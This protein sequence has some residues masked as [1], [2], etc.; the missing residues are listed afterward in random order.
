[1]RTLKDIG[2]SRGKKVLVRLDL[3]VPI[4][5]G[6]VQNDFRIRQSLPTINFLKEKGARLILVSHLGKNGEESLEP[7]FTVLRKHL[8]EISFYSSLP[9]DETLKEKIG[10][11][12]DGEILLLENLRKNPGEEKNGLVFSKELASLADLYVND[13]FSAS[14]REHASIVGVPKIISGYA[15]FLLEKEVIEL[16]KVLNPEHPFIFIL[17]GAKFSTKIPLVEKYL[18]Q[19][20]SIF[21][22]GA[23]AHDFWHA[24]GLSVGKSLLDTDVRVSSFTKEEKISLPQDLIARLGEKSE[25]KTIENVLPDE[26]IV[27][28]GPATIE[29]LAEKIKGAKLVVWNGPLGNFEAGFNEGTESLAKKIAESG[30]YSI[31]GGGDTLSAI[32]SLGLF[33]K[34]S[35]VSTGGGAMLDFLGTGTLP[36]IE[37]LRD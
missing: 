28:A 18:T 34:F 15:G 9:P 23:L 16:S 24:K 8:P 13:A 5:G 35:F 19:A 37:A 22:G 36:G 25:I 17:G 33:E 6:V 26:I 4:E 1:M 2:D 30:T 31:V 11:M 3:N 20:D 32:E 27:D 14:H 7:V 29:M 10:N 12:K 21:I